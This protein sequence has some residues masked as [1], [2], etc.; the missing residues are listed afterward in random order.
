[1]RLLGHLDIALHILYIH[2]F[3]RIDESELSDEC[4]SVVCSEWKSDC[5]PFNKTMA[6]R[7][8]WGLRDS[9]DQN[10][11]Q[12]QGRLAWL[13]VLDWRGSG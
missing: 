9:F 3:R 10:R 4:L 7:T 8:G 1:M 12:P 5:A 6:D 13:Q 11:F 2:V